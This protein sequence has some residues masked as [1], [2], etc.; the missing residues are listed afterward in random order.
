MYT[1]HTNVIWHLHD[2]YK[3]GSGKGVERAFKYCSKVTI[4][5]VSRVMEQKTGG[6]GANY[7]HC[8]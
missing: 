7:L 6:D 5:R 3:I 2:K 1:I 4:T 8:R